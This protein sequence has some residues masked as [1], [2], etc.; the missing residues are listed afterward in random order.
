MNGTQHN[1]RGQVWVEKGRC[2]ARGERREEKHAWMRDRRKQRVTT[3]ALAFIR[4]LPSSDRVYHVPP[5]C[6]S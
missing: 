5:M 1:V 6:L 2:G 3:D 4:I